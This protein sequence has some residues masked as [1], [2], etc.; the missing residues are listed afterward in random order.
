MT[1]RLIPSGLAGLFVIE[2]VPARDDRGT[3]TRLGCVS[4]FAAHGID[5]TPRQ[6]SLSRSTHR[7]TLRGMHFQTTPAQEVKL[8]YCLSGSIH[9]VVFDPR[10]DSPTRGRYFTIELN[11]ANGLGLLIPAGCAHGFLTLTENAAVLYQIDRDH[12]PSR[13]HG[14][15]WDDPFFAA[16][17]PAKPAVISDRDATWPDF[18]P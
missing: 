6:T 11:R 3:F 10:P 17:W 7:H 16:A 1:M 9:D 14:L 4:T 5:F 2:T 8:V 12:D 15:R 18:A 13:A